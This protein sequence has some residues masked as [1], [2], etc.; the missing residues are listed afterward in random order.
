M[1]KAPLPDDG[2]RPR[3][4]VADP[5]EEIAMRRRLRDLAGREVTAPIVLLNPNASD[6]MPLRR[7]PTEV[8][9]PINAAIP[10]GRAIR[11][12]K[13]RLRIGRIDLAKPVPQEARE[14]L[15]RVS[16]EPGK[17]KLQT[18]LSA[19]DSTSRGA[20]FVYARRVS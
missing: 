6:L 20:Y 11:A 10:G 12:D 19:D 2:Y 3:P 18:W 1:L 13:A 5:E 7:W 14:I 16:L 8:N 4:F 9:A 17:M 15:F